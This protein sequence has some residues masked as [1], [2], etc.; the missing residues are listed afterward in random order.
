MNFFLL[1]SVGVYQ[2]GMHDFESV[3]HKNKHLCS[4]YSASIL[5][6][7]PFC[8]QVLDF[9]AFAEPEFDLP[10]FCANFFTAADRNIVV[11]W[12]YFVLEIWFYSTSGVLFLADDMIAF[13]SIRSSKCLMLIVWTT[14]L[15][16]RCLIILEILSW[17]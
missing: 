11:L 10:I 2:F 15:V 8:S 9:A 1:I 17:L 6:V 13:S 4:V 7:P 12:V 14:T 3:L 5:K 16:L